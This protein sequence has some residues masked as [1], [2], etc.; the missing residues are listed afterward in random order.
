MGDP[1]KQLLEPI[2]DLDQPAEPCPRPK[3]VIVITKETHSHNI[4]HLT[5]RVT[6]T[7]NGF[8]V[9]DREKAILKRNTDAGLTNLI[10]ELTSILSRYEW[11]SLPQHL[12]DALDRD[13]Q[14]G[15]EVT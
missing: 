2:T 5:E 4:A 12:R 11:A 8:K 6:V 7:M 15:G 14:E 1:Q 10:D 9:L 3:D 13:S